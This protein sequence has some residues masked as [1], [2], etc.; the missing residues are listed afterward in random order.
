MNLPHT[1]PAP[2]SE[3]NNRHTQLALAASISSVFTRILSDTSTCLYYY[4]MLPVLPFYKVPT[5]E[6]WR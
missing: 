3:S 5:A 2:R 4:R 1:P 6:I